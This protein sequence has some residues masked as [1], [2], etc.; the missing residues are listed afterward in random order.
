MVDS[1]RQYYRGYGDIILQANYDD[2]NLK[3]LDY[4]ITKLGGV[5]SVELKFGQAAKGI[6]GMGRVKAIEDALRFQEMGYL[7]YPDPSDPVIAENYREG[8]G[9]LFEKK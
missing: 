2:E 7:I 6:Q 9:P 8:K 1:F 4:A 3:L 5:K